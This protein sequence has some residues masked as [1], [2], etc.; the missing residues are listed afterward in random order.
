[1]IQ[2]RKVTRFVTV[3]LD[4]LKSSW[5]GCSL[6]RIRRT[7]ADSGMIAFFET[8]TIADSFHTAE[9]CCCQAYVKYM[10]KDTDKLFLTN[11]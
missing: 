11:L 5:E 7:F 6:T 3:G 10:F 4:L 9:K 2:Q 8:D 1:V